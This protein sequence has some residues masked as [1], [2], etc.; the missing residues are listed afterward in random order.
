[1]DTARTKAAARLVLVSATELQ[2]QRARYREEAHL[3]VPA[4]PVL[5]GLNTLQHWLWN[6]IG[7]PTGREALTDA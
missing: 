6:R 3:F 1:L 4:D 7:A 2:W 5:L